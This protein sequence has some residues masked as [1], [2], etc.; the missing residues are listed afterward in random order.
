[1]SRLRDVIK[2]ADD[3]E[4]RTVEVPEWPHPD[5]DNEPVVLMLRAPTLHRRNQLM[6]LFSRGRGNDDGTVDTGDMDW[7]G[8]STALLSEMVFDPDDMDAGPLFADPADRDMLLEKSGAVCWRI[9]NECMVIAG[10]SQADE[11][12]E[13]VAP[14]SALVDAGKDSSFSTTQQAETSTS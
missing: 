3:L 8:L 5:K 14:E 7:D 11:A 9:A 4:Q 6:R 1:M 2:S 12:D 13:S 10:F